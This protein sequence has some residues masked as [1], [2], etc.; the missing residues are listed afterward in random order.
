MRLVG[1]A[2]LED[3]EILAVMNKRPIEDIGHS[4]P[5]NVDKLA[6]RMRNFILNEYETYLIVKD[7][8]IS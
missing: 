3:V 4:N 6:E 2:E 8:E 5:M 1:N 7:N